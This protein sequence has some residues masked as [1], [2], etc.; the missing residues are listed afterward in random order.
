MYAC[1]QLGCDLYKNWKP[2]SLTLHFVLCMCKKHC[3]QDFV[4]FSCVHKHTH[5]NG[6]VRIWRHSSSAEMACPHDHL[7]QKSAWG[8]SPAC[9]IYTTKA[10]GFGTEEGPP[11]HFACIHHKRHWTWICKLNLQY[12]MWIVASQILKFC[13]LTCL[14]TLKVAMLKKLKFWLLLC[15]PVFLEVGE[16][17]SQQNVWYSELLWFKQL[18]FA[19]NGNN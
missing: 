17:T 4:T 1:T 6:Q 3:L 2:E 8:F 12:W 7:L 15:F 10:I 19:K 9:L 5:T 14:D 13:Q 18:Y 16:G 11:R